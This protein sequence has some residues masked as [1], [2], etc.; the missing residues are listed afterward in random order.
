M[1]VLSDQS[2]KTPLQW[3]TFFLAGEMFGF[4]VMGVQEVMNDQPI[5][6]VPLAPAHVVGLLTLRGEIMSAIDLRRLLGCAPRPDG[7][8]AKLVIIRGEGRRVGLIVD[9]IGDVLEL[10]PTDWQAP[11]ETMP[12]EQRRFVIGIHPIEEQ[13]VIGLDVGAVLSDGLATENEVVR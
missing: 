1:S 2:N 11:P 13:L 10:P 6:P 12:A 7:K 5:T 4:P 8:R 3:S 9:A